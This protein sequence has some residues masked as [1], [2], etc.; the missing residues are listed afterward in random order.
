MRVGSNHTFAFRD[1]Q[2]CSGDTCGSAETKTPTHRNA[3]VR[4]DVAAATRLAER[5]ARWM[6]CITGPRIC[7]L[8]R[9][10]G[11]RFEAKRECQP[12]RVEACSKVGG[13]C[14]H[15]DANHEF[16]VV[17]AP[18]GSFWQ[19]LPRTPA[20]S[21]ARRRAPQIRGKARVAVFDHFGQHDVHEDVD[22][23]HEST[24]R[25]DPKAAD[26]LSLKLA[27][28]PKGFAKS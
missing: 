14:R 28:E 12:E 18:V 3:V 11:A 24:G 25:P 15:R 10:D 21:P 22:C 19:E 4:P 17:S 9:V 16:S 1:G 7:W 5:D 2:Q 8:L 13:A 26:R 27:N 6:M 20:S 23:P